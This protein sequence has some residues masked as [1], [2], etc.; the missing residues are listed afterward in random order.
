MLLGGGKTAA[1]VLPL[2]CW[3]LDLPAESRSVESSPFAIIMAPTREYVSIIIYS[4]SISFLHQ[5]LNAVFLFLRRLAVQI[6]E[7]TR[8]F[9]DK[10]GITVVSI[11]GGISETEQASKLRNGCDIVI[12]TPG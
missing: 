9:A 5:S 10:L 4:P 11:I 8:K 7:E 1:F 12:A 6:E 3:I 2:I